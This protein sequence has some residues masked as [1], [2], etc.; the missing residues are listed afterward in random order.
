MRKKFNKAKL[1]IFNV[2]SALKSAPKSRSRWTFRGPIKRNFSSLFSFRLCWSNLLFS[3]AKGTCGL[4]WKTNSQTY[5]R[6]VEKIIQQKYTH[7]QLR[8]MKFIYPK[9][10]FMRAHKKWNQRQTIHDNGIN[11]SFSSENIH[12]YIEH[13]IRQ[14]TATKKNDLNIFT[15]LSYRLRKWWHDTQ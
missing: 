8:K 10:Y 15:T 3:C 4:I 7:T 1:I 14:L 11:V 12:K 9:E 5:T 2:I 6:F 13:D